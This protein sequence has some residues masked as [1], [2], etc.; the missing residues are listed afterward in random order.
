[1]ERAINSS[2]ALRNAL[3]QAPVVWFDFGF[4]ASRG[5]RI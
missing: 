4:V 3:A 5:R 2:V 1:L